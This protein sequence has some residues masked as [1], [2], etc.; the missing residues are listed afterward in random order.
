MTLAPGIKLGQYEI[1]SQLGAGGMGEV[2]RAFDTQLKQEVAIKILPHQ[3]SS[4]P[5]RLLRFQQEAEAAAALNHPNILSVHHVGRQDGNPFIVTELLQ[6]QTLREML[7]TGPLSIRKAVEYAT[8]IVDGLAVAHEKGIIHRDLKPENIFITKDSRV[9]ILDFGLAKLTQPRDELSA[10]APTVDVQTGSGV[11]LGTVGYMSPEQVRGHAADPRSDIFAFGAVL[12][13][14]L[15]GK[16]AFRGD[17]PADT[18]SAI[19]KDEPPDLSGLVRQAPPALERIVRHCLEKSPRQRFQ[20]ARDLVYAL[21]TVSDIT[22]SS[23]SSVVPATAEHKKI[24]IGW[25]AVSLTAITALG[26][27]LAWWLRPAAPAQVESVLQLTHD[28]LPK[29]VPASMASDGS[30][31]YF[32]ERRSGSLG[33]AQVSLAGGESVPLTSGL[34]N[35]FVLDIAPDS[36]ALLVKYGTEGDA[37][38]GLLPLPAGQLRKIAKA[39]S[40]ALFPDGQSIAYCSESSMYVAQKDGSNAHKISDVGCYPDMPLSISPDGR[41]IRFPVVSDAGDTPFYWEIRADGTQLH[42][43]PESIQ[44]WSGKWTSDGKLFIFVRPGNGH[45]DLW[46]LPKKSGILSRSQSPIRLTNGPLSY[47]GPLPS[48]DGQ[49][50]YAIGVQN[51]G[52]LI[53]YDV[54]SRQFL[55]A[56]DGISATDV[57]YS[58]DGKWLIYLSY[59]NHDLWRSRADGTE[60]LQLTYP[61]MEVLWPHISPDAKRV[62]FSGYLPKRGFGTYIV[63]MAGR[64]PKFVTASGASSAWSLDGKSLLISVQLPGKKSWNFDSVQLGTLDIESGKI[65]TIPD[66]QGKGGAFQPTA[67]MI[68]SAGVQDKLYWFDRTTEKWS[69][70]ADGPIQNYMIS[71]DS[72]YLYFV[73]ETPEN[74]QAMRVRLADR[75]VEVVASLKGVRRVADPELGGSSWVGVTPDGSLLLTRDTGTQEVY[76]LNLR[77]P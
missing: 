20:S 29:P 66:S 65:A 18:Q 72:K 24:P 27:G 67:E 46:A 77:W 12:Y 53:R 15:S 14:M 26:A 10:N 73:R 55:P 30:R 56:L 28:G 25:I 1:V 61:P 49:R 60:R 52:E 44:G 37:F 70:L 62:Q 58:P 22:G 36:S 32:T 13:E 33:I 38:V 35:P 50:I 43:L 17:T 11:L 71:P 41:R 19:L 34:V 64:E 54:A 6:G 45:V 8:Q 57:M 76:A 3:H 31:L 39:D 51:R 9:K 16:R 74:P 5:E 23:G 47:D 69:L 63:D 68:V 2:Y 4:D 21:E 59:P 40:A 42:A 48:R 7:R 75:K